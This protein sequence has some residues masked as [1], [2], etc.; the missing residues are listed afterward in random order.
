MIMLIQ[1]FANRES[2]I[3]VVGKRGLQFIKTLTI[4]VRNCT[5]AIRG[6]SVLRMS[7]R[8]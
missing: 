2:A 5:G 8:P 6:V 4:K 7:L 1:S 3:D